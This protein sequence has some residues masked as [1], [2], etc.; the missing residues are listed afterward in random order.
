[1]GSRGS[2]DLMGWYPD[3]CMI[4]WGHLPVVFLA[5]TS[6]S[7]NPQNIFTM[8]KGDLTLMQFHFIGDVSPSVILERE[9]SCLVAVPCS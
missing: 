7:L 3:Y 1:M 6:K 4:V 8:G 9:T 2:R 5:V